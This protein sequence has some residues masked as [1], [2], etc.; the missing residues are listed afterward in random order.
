MFG[1]IL[2][3]ETKLISELVQSRFTKSVNGLIT[4][5]E[6]LIG[7][8]VDARGTLVGKIQVDENTREYNPNSSCQKCVFGSLPRFPPC[9]YID[10]LLLPNF[11]SI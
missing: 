6:N 10:A 7:K 2:V 9:P 8:K 4:N 1:R 5:K 3:I 11:R